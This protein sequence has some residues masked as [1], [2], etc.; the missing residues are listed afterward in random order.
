MKTHMKHDTRSIDD[1]L[2]EKNLSGQRRVWIENH[3]KID[4][5]LDKANPYLRNERLKVTEVGIGD[6]HLLKKL[7]EMGM[8]CTGV[9]ISDYLINHHKKSMHEGGYDIEFIKEDIRFVDDQLINNQD[10]VFCVDILEHLDEEGYFKSIQNIYTILKKNG[11]FIGSFPYEENLSKN[12]V[13]C[14]ECGKEFHRVG[15]QHSIDLAKFKNSIEGMFEIVSFGN[16]LRPFK[17]FLI[18]ILKSLA[19]LKISRYVQG[20]T[21]YFIARRC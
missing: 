8:H 20:G 4:F 19:D 5:I 3:P 11:L 14:P 7:C 13:V 12:I 2:A 6:A 1:H 21:V 18:P 17:S 16:V 15:H 10:A 9:D